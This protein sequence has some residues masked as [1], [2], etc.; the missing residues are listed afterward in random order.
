MTRIDFYLNAS[1][2]L[3]IACRIA[4]KAVS[5]Q[6]RILIMAPDEA[7]AREIDRLMWINPAT[8]F[9]P[10]CMSTDKLAVE[11]PVLIAR[12]SEALPHDELLLNLGIQPPASFSRFRRLVEIVS[13]DEV[14]KQLA[15]ER[16]RFYKD[17]GYELHHHDLAITADG[18]TG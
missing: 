4:A 11:T 14:D 7:V 2:K 16:F 6:M 9:L 8:G 17:R 5:Q 12:S 18:Q 3:Q 1:H 10:H 13:H 15:R